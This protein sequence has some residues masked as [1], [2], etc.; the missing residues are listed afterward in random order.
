MEFTESWVEVKES[1]YWEEVEKYRAHR[2][3]GGE[4]DLDELRASSILR[5][6]SDSCYL[7]VLSYSDHPHA[8]LH[9]SGGLESLTNVAKYG[10]SKLVES[11]AF[12]AFYEDIIWENG[13]NSD[14]DL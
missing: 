11:M 1:D 10:G 3:R 12:H 9:Q 6:L 2:A 5:G 13:G 7:R 14:E 4:I 8:L